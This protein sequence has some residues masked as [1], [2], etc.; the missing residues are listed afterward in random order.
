MKYLFGVAG[1][2]VLCAGLMSWNLI[3][4]KT[5]AQIAENHLTPQARLAV[6]VFLNGSVTD[7]D[8]WTDEIKNDTSYSVKDPFH[9]LNLPLGL[10]YA[11]FKQAM[12]SRPEKNIYNILIKCQ[13]DI[14]DQNVSMDKK[15]IALKILVYLIIDIHLP[16]D[17]TEAANAGNTVQIQFDGEGT[18]LHS[19]W[20]SKI[21]SRLDTDHIELA[22][23]YDTATVKQVDEWQQDDILKWVYESYSIGCELYAENKNGMVLND[24]HYNKYLPVVKQRLEMGGVRLAGVLNQ[25]FKSFKITKVELMPPP[26]VKFVPPPPP[27]T[28][29]TRRRRHH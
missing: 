13:H 10:N 1:S 18:G 14:S 26:P 17:V 25:L 23:A 11:E 5:V 6:Y 21:I 2:V 3:E 16:T 20:Y 15:R 29:P 12:E 9:F 27:P 24:D 19:L 28:S 4:N 22:K 7:V 8:A